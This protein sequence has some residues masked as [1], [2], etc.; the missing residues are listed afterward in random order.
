MSRR[1][2]LLLISGPS[3]CGKGTVC[4]QLLETVPNMR[5]SIS[6]TTRPPRPGE[7]HGR[8]YY[9]MTREGF[10]RL[11]Q[12]GGFLEWAPIYGNLYGTPA[13]PVREML[14]AGEDIILEIDVQGGLQVKEHFPDTIL[15]F[16][17]TPSRAM[18][19]SRLTG[20]GTDSPEDIQKRLL[21]VDTELGFMS[22]YDYVLVNDRLSDTI[23][24]IRCIL[25]A[26]RSRSIRSGLP[27]G[28]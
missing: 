1:G 25:E 11:A 6:A 24:K 18:L 28:W 21:W 5:L 20:R 9:F 8:N 4:S 22:R 15:I 23:E 12:E 3:G 7:V 26:E 13:A 2:M 17:I 10:E 14:A 16:L 19:E 27:E